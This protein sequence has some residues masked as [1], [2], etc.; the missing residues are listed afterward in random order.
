MLFQNPLKQCTLEKIAKRDYKQS[1]LWKFGISGDLP[2]ILVKIKDTNDIYIINELLKAYEMYLAKGIKV[3]LVILNEEELEYE[4]YV[5]EE[6]ETAII[7]KQLGYLKNNGID[8]KKY[9][10]ETGHCIIIEF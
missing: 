8:Y 5:K 4:Q 7:N 10:N 9:N 2:I 1:D 3:D 6:I